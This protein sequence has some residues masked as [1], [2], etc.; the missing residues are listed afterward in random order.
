MV[1]VL[2]SGSNGY[3]RYAGRSYKLGWVPNNTNLRTYYIK[4]CR[5]HLNVYYICPY[6]FILEH[7][8]RRGILH[9]L[10]LLRFLQLLLRNLRR[11]SLNI[12]RLLR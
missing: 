1:Q 2:H 9:L 10:D 4:K 3:S 7:C 11:F 5:E 6:F 8:I 12:E